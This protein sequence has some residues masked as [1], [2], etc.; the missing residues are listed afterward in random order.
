MNPAP[1][2]RFAL[3]ES[4]PPWGV[5][6]LESHHADQFYME[7]RTHDFY[8][9]IYVAHG[10][11]RLFIGKKSYPFTSG[12]LLWVPAS[13]RNRLTDDRGAPCSLY[14]L[15]LAPSVFAFDRPLTRLL[16]PGRISFSR[17]FAD[18]AIQLIK[19]MVYQQR[20]RSR[21]AS[22]SMVADGLMLFRMALEAAGQDVATPRQSPEGDDEMANYV[23]RLDATFFE[24][25]TIDEAAATLGISRRSFTKRF[26]ELTGCS[27][28]T[29]RQQRSVEHACR[30]LLE[31]QASIT[32]IA[33]E[34]GYA[35]LSS[36]YR[37]FKKHRGLAP[38]VW[39]REARSAN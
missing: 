34:C 5:G 12:N 39:R 30:L 23:R 32:S 35:D 31:T 36:F 11:G 16:R 33:F 10:S 13:R 3:P 20:S 28:V 2:V 19:R 17:H 14:I 38:A 7:W 1:L 15:C 8:K 22:I 29:Y 4:L 27:W 21:R 18:Q 25:T 9:L 6:I 24:S 26:R 37:S